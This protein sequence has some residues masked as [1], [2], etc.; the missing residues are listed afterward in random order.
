MGERMLSAERTLPVTQA[1]T[2][3]AE[4]RLAVDQGL[5]LKVIGWNG[6]EAD[7]ACVCWLAGSEKESVEEAEHESVEEAEQES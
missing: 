5:G 7:C 3:A 6:M 2:D 1:V 4:V